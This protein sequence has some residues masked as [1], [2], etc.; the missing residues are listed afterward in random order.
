ML[1]ALLIG[2][3]SVGYSQTTKTLSIKVA[4]QCEH[5]QERIEE[6]LDQPGII[7]AKWDRKS[8]LVMIKADTARI[9]RAKISKLL[10]DAGH[11]TELDKATDQAYDKLPGCCKYRKEE[12]K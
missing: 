11:D 3:S 6:A 9:S 5:C 4:G 1:T 8:K 10:A 7:K 2:L 12:K